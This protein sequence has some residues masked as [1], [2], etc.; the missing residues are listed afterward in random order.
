MLNTLILEYDLNAGL[1]KRF[2]LIHQNE[3]PNSDWSRDSTKTHLTTGNESIYICNF[4]LTSWPPILLSLG[5]I[6]Y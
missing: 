1:N 6:N 5:E 2:F 3:C 4:I